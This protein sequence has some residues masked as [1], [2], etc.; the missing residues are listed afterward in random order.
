MRNMTNEE[1]V[2]IE[3]EITELMRNAISDDYTAYILTHKGEENENTI[4]Q[5]VIDDVLFSS[6]WGEEGYYNED[7]IRLSI[8]R[9]LMDRL[10]VVR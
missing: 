1:R 9:I 10:G 4:M 5:D 3:R 2:R 7:D 6:A 8:G